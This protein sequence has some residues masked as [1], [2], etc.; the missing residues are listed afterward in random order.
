MAWTMLTPAAVE[1]S[2]PSVLMSCGV[3]V[4]T[5][6]AATALDRPPVPAKSSKKMPSQ[7]SDSWAAT[8]C[9]ASGR[10]V[11]DA[12]CPMTDGG[13]GVESL[14]VFGARNGTGAESNA[15]PSC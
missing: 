6:L 13:G 12:G 10:A 2:A 8:S 15:L 5:P 4:G 14:L 9:G 11:E 3:S 7:A 1:R